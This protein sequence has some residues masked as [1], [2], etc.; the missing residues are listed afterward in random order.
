MSVRGN[1]QLPLPPG[2]LPLPP[3]LR[4]CLGARAVVWVRVL[5]P[6]R[7]QIALMQPLRK[8]LIKYEL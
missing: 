3:G 6:C 5:S 8:P 1:W 2:L 7:C 4:A